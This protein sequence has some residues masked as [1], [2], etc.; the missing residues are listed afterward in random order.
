MGAW[1]LLNTD[2]SGFRL[3]RALL[4]SWLLDMSA[5]WTL[6]QVESTWTHMGG[7]VGEPC[8]PLGALG[9]AG[10]ELSSCLSSGDRRSVGLDSGSDPHLG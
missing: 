4:L 10:E 5:S 2:D 6:I 7:R 8:C 9:R 3:Q 1:Q